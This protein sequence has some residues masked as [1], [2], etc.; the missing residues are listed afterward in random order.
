[1]D[2]QRAYAA[3]DEPPG[4]LDTML[5]KAMRGGSLSDH[6]MNKLY[7]VLRLNLIGTVLITL[8]FVA[9]AFIVQEPLVL[10]LFSALLVFSAWSVVDGVRLL[11]GWGAGV[12]CTNSLLVEMQRQYDTIHRWMRLQM[13][14]ALAVYP[15]S[16]AGGFLW[17]GMEGSG[18]DALTFLQKPMVGV[19]LAVSIIVLVPVCYWAA[20][21]LSKVA[22]GRHLAA[23]RVRIEELRS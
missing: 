9:L 12:S 21:W 11:R 17:G 16:I 23:L 20:K 13:R 4:D 18:L 22:F 1:M 10:V 14:V 2:L 7:R 3:M 19:V 15:F 5:R 6:P 8:V